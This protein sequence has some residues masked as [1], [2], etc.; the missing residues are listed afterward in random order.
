MKYI[1]IYKCFF[2]QKTIFF[3]N[4]QDKKKEN[5][6]LARKKFGEWRIYCTRRLYAVC[7]YDRRY[8]FR[9]YQFDVWNVINLY[10]YNF[11]TRSEIRLFCFSAILYSYG[12]YF[13][14][15]FLKINL[16]LPFSFCGACRA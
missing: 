11:F 7:L 1:Y 15:L 16:Q 14:F 9:I 2:Y 6:I 12:I 4:N 3:A 13:L 5:I 10:I 8:R